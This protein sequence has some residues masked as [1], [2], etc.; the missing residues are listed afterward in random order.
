MRVGR[1]EAAILTAE[2]HPKMPPDT[3]R[4]NIGSRQ[5]AVAQSEAIIIALIDA[6]V[7]PLHVA[8]LENRLY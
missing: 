7:V 3:C 1:T 6:I 4:S 5:A 2:R 8:F